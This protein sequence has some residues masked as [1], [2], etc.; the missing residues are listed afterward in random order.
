LKLASKIYSEIVG[1]LKNISVPTSQLDVFNQREVHIIC[2]G[3]SA[4]NSIIG[5]NSANERQ[6]TI[7]LNS[8][9]FHPMECDYY[10]WEASRSTS[11]MK[12]Y[13]EQL[14]FKKYIKIF[15]PHQSKKYHKQLKKFDNII[16]YRTVPYAASKY[17]LPFLIYKYLKMKTY[18]YD[19]Y[20]SGSTVMRV[21]N[22]LIKN[23]AS[24]IHLHGL[25]LSNEY[26]PQI[27]QFDT[28]QTGTIHTTESA[29]KRIKLTEYFTILKL[30]QNFDVF[31]TKIIYHGNNNQ[32]KKILTE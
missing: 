15:S 3:A 25:D 32:L 9:I 16:Y 8:F 31:K 22:M 24:E 29:L 5:I 14:E 21:I 2:P 17:E 6:V 28:R 20:G 27:S 4:S 7:G 10:F 23:K 19:F 30:L 18:R 11:N 26:I 1:K 13:L 12:L